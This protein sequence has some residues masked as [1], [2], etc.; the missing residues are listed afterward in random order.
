MLLTVKVENVGTW[1]STALALARFG[2]SQWNGSERHGRGIIFSDRDNELILQ[3][4][5]T[6]YV[7]D[8]DNN[9]GVLHVF[10]QA[11]VRLHERWYRHLKRYAVFCPSILIKGEW[12]PSFYH[13]VLKDRLIKNFFVK[14]EQDWMI[15][16]C[17]SYIRKSRQTVAS[18][19]TF[20][21]EIGYKTL[22]A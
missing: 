16:K 19:S 13:L 20:I 6:P 5:V 18:L 3:C 12:V 9:T 7:S 14:F 1:Q 8:V 11:P 15:R 17:F 4:I 10:R 2:P 22:L 21:S